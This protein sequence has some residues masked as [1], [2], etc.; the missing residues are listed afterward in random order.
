VETLVG[1]TL[2][3][4]TLTRFVGSGGMGTVYLAEDQ[5]IGQQVAI[6]VVRTD[7][8][9]YF[10]SASGG[11]AEERFKQEARAVASLDHLHI[12]PLY[13]YGEEET[14]DGRRAYMV[15]QYRPEGSLWD[16]LRRRAGI[17]SGESLTLTPGSSRQLQGL[18]T[19]WPLGIE[20][21][22]DYLR[23]A[24]S[25]LQYAHERGIVHRDVKPANFL[26][27]FDAQRTG[28]L[29]P[30]VFLLLSDFGLAKFFSSISATSRVLGT[31]TYMAPEQFEGAAGPES[32]QYALAVMIYYFLAGR[33]PFEGE[34]MHLMHQHLS[35]Q[36]PPIRTFAPTLSSGIEK[37]L[38]RALAKQPVARYPSIAA[39]AEDFSQR[40]YEEQR[41]FS[42]P[43][44][45]PALS[46][47]NPLAAQVPTMRDTAS[48]TAHSAPTLMPQDQAEE[49]LARS[50]ADLST[51]IQPPS[52]RSQAQVVA[53]APTLYPPAD[54]APPFPR[55]PHM[56]AQDRA[57]ATEQG[58]A[59]TPAGKRGLKRRSALGWIIAGAALA[60]LGTAAGIYFY[61]DQQ[62]DHARYILRGHSGQVTGLSWS[63]GGTELASA[64]Y[65]HTARLWLF[66]STQS[67]V[68][69]TGHRAGLLS[70]AW[71]PDGTL[72][73]S[74]GRDETVQVW[75]SAGRIKYRF[76]SL[77]APVSS[78]AWLPNGTRLFAGTL[79]AGLH[80]LTLGV[81]ALPPKNARQE[82]I[83]ALAVSPDGHYLA[84]GTETG[85]VVIADL[86]TG[87][88]PLSRRLHTQPV[89]SLAWSPDSLLL[90]SGGADGRARVLDLATDKVTYS[91]QHSNSVTGVAWDPA[92]TAHLATACAD[93]YL[94]LWTAEGS[95]RSTYATYGGHS[96]AITSIAWG[97]KGLATGSADA[98]II[99][100]NI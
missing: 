12:L 35:V 7:E 88:R 81:N 51:V 78:V 83:H 38:A 70:I 82:I 85:N 94:R 26:L 84:I 61:T 98:T 68:T 24:A 63:P 25:A 10:D 56:P 77:S 55:S 74:G 44:S 34:P 17:V 87:H 91:V 57:S 62:P 96:S 53:S 30:G 41:N 86:Q 31:P 39:F 13:R 18:P 79:G 67:A 95:Q 19:A 58:Q 45:L 11:R 4:Y 16:W 36:A 75:D 92:G 40:M 90:A 69:Y 71:S 3:G 46:Q 9:E 21:A 33:P 43:F 93:G 52:T 89:L 22:A 29:A 23:Q 48:F 14:P 27:R 99:I 72:L 60:G 54:A 59:D 6:K 97:A 76:A 47:R 15:M 28:H 49:T 66:G 50:Q 8:D 32:D 65:D 37:A 1:T 80:T 42:P 100:W 2:G 20:E 73:A 64:S 5:A